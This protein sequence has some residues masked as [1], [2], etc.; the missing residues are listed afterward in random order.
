MSARTGAAGIPVED[1]CEI[2]SPDSLFF[3]AKAMRCAI[4]RRYKHPAEF[5]AFGPLWHRGLRRIN[6]VNFPGPGPSL[7]RTSMCS[8][9]GCSETASKCVVK[10]DLFIAQY[11]LDI[12]NNRAFSR[13]HNIICRAKGPGKVGSPAS[14]S[15]DRVEVAQFCELESQGSNRRG[16]TGLHG[17]S[18]PRC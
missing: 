10:L 7:S 16:S 1:I 15:D 18:R 6:H 5:D 12:P 14:N 4:C 11:F 8:Q 13:V 17:A 2:S 9:L 3:R